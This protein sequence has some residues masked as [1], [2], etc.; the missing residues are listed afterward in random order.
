[1]SRRNT[2]LSPRCRRAISTAF[3]P[4]IPRRSRSPFSSRRSGV[5]IR[6]AAS[7]GH[8]ETP[9]TAPT[10]GVS[11][12]ARTS[13]MLTIDIADPISPPEHRQR[14]DDHPAHEQHDERP[15]DQRDGERDQATGLDRQTLAGHGLRFR[16]VGRR[17]I[18]EHDE[19]LHTS[20]YHLSD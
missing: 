12:S 5:T 16:P 2:T 20:L 17:K 18:R 4:S 8:N 1:R 13:S 15:L 11:T 10:G 19:F 7:S 14:L 6:A 3:G 9:T